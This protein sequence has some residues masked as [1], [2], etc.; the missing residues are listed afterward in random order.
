MIKIEIPEGLPRCD[1][2][3]VLAKKIEQ[4][5]DIDFNFFGHLDDFRKRVSDEMRQVNELFPE[6][7]PHDEQ[8]HLKRLFHVADTILGR[9]RLEAMN[10]A[11]LFVLAVSLYGHDWG[12]A[13][14]HQEKQYILTK[15]LPKG[16]SVDDFWILPDEHTRL[17]QFAHKQRLATD[18]ESRFEKIPIEMWRIYIR[19]THAYRSSER[20]YQFFSTIDGGVAEAAKRVCEGHGVEFENLQDH[21]LY[22]SEFSVLRENINLRALAVYVRLIDLLDLGEDRTP[23][24]IWKFVDPKDARSKMTWMKHRALIPVTCAPYQTGRIIRV[25]GSTDDHEVYAALEDLRIWCQ[26]QL[27]GCNDVLARMKDVRHR[28]D[29]YDIDWRVA[30]RGFKKLSIQF[31]FNRERMFEIL[32]DEIYNGDPYVFLRELLQ[33]SVDAIRM[34]REV[35]QSKGI[36]L[37]DLGA[38]YVDVKHENNGDAVITWRDDGIGMDEYI[39]QNYLSVA[40]KSYYRSSDFER[41]GLKMDPISK[42]GIGILSCFVAAERIEIETFKDPYLYPSGDRLKIIIPAIN[43]QFRIEIL[44]AES[45]PIGTTVKVFVEGRKIPLDDKSKSVKPLD[46]TGYLSIVAGFVEFPI[47]ITEADRKTIVLHPKQDA[48]A[49]RQRFGEEYKVHQLDLR[50]PWSEAFLPQDLSMAREILREEQRDIASDFDLEGYEGAVTYLVPT[51]DSFDLK[52]YS[53]NDQIEILSKGKHIKTIRKTEIMSDYYRIKYFGLSHSS[54]QTT[55]YAVYR[56]GILLSAASKPGLLYPDN[57]LPVPRY[58]VNIPKTISP[59]IDLARS[60]VI[61]EF[62][63]WYDVVDQASQNYILKKFLKGLLEQEPAE[64]LYQLGRLISFYNIRH[65]YLLQVFPIKNLPLPFLESGG[66]LNILEWQIAA[67]DVL[68]GPPE[69][70]N[71]YTSRGRGYIRSISLDFFSKELSKLGLCQWL[72]HDKYDGAL[73]LW[74]GERCLLFGFGEDIG[75]VAS[76]SIIRA[77]E[78][79]QFFIRE[80]YRFEAIRFLHPPWKGYPPLLQRIWR[81]KTVSEDV[82]DIQKVLEKASENPTLLNHEEWELFFNDKN[83]RGSIPRI[84]EFTHPFEQAFAYGDRL[85]NLKHPVTQALIRFVALLKLSEMNKNLPDDRIGYLDDALKESIDSIRYGGFKGRKIP[86]IFNNLW[87]LA[88][89]TKLFEIGEIDKLAL[90]P[91]DFITMPSLPIDGEIQPFGMPL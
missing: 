12:M 89:E 6:Y 30:A 11:E 46:V 25:D 66:H 44:S 36:D 86:D 14:S 67:N 87:S 78:M 28:L 81:R 70:I 45:A 60:K 1:L 54:M 51:D 85:L 77:G 47:I 71:E 3:E 7:T 20:V 53:S 90:T 52:G 69:F 73:T 84:I 68:Y 24:V 57:S 15:E 58:L 35:L 9:E 2:I 21:Y 63:R 5:H 16:K 76:N 8:Y 64:R 33:N 79:G 83:I 17:A 19:E 39:I 88:R 62:E 37:K 34:R 41:L 27:R 56:D 42:F 22:P 59:K 74:N 23:Y 43:R 26:Q 38:I 29:I 50:Y 91:A 72:T 75:E 13:V 10:S 49:A 40:G 18:T 65:K 55:T 80:F 31:E 32:S 82:L 61:G 48:E 4:R